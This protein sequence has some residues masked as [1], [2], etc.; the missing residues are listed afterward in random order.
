MVKC[1]VSP[2]TGIWHV[3]WKIVE[4]VSHTFDLHLTAPLYIATLGLVEEAPCTTTVANILAVIPSELTCETFLVN[5]S[6]WASEAD[7]GNIGCLVSSTSSRRPS[8]HP[9]YLKHDS[10]LTTDD[11]SRCKH[12]AIDWT[13]RWWFLQ[14]WS[15][16]CVFCKR[17]KLLG[18]TINLHL[19]APLCIAPLG[20]IEEA[21]CTTK[22]WYHFVVIAS[23]LTCKTLLMNESRRASGVYGSGVGCL[24]VAMVAI[25]WK[26]FS[27]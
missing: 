4:L 20:L 13:P 19:T 18:N 27:F 17:F 7:G 23:K 9:R 16:V 24:G 22:V 8:R 14:R 12:H 6:R 15:N 11:T 1:K 26:L 21:P 5:E 10:F 3:I 2:L 25:R